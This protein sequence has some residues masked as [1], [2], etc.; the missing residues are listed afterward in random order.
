MPNKPP[1]GLQSPLRRKLL[2]GTAAA[3]AA[4]VL[5]V[6]PSALAQAFPLGKGIVVPGC[7]HFSAIPHALTKAAV[8][9]FIDG[10]LDDPWAR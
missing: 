2:L 7:D 4:A 8:F 6:P 10:V 9:D 1:A 5:G 3:S